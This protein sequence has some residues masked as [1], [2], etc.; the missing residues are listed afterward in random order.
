MRHPVSANIHIAWSALRWL[1]YD[2]IAGLSLPTPFTLSEEILRSI[3]DCLD[4]GSLPAFA[5]AIGNLELTQVE[6]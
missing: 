3:N 5:I 6:V 1:T 4:I 2:D